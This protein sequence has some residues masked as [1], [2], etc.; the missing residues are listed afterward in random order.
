MAK[1]ITLVDDIDGTPIVDGQG[2]T[3][4]YAVG[5]VS[6][7]IDLNTENQSA[8]RAALAPYIEHSRKAVATTGARQSGRKAPGSD[9]PAI[10]EW[11][12]KNGFEVSQRGRI[13]S[14]VRAAYEAAH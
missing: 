9:I 6:Y 14:T 7:E 2:G 4:A 12:R 3:I 5:G 11:A 1:K 13:S 10:R 8:L